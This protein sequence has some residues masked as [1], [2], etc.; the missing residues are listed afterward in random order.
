MK[1]LIITVGLLAASPALAGVATGDCTTQRGTKIYYGISDAKGFLYYDNDGPHQ[2]FSERK[3][4]LGIIN[5]IGNRGNMRMAIDLDTG[6][7]YIVTRMDDGRV[8]EGNV[9]C[10]LGYKE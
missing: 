6:R 10:K 8:I 2:I 5:H 7:G 9:V 1:A 3:G 4:N